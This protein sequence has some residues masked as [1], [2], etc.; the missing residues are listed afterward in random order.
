MDYAPALGL[1]EEVLFQPGK[2]CWKPP[3]FASGSLLVDGTAYYS[4]LY[5]TLLLAQERVFIQGWDFCSEV[6]LPTPQS[7]DGK[8]SIPLSELL[9]KLVDDRPHLEVKIL[10]WDAKPYFSRFRESQDDAKTVLAHPRI[11]L[12][13][14]SHLPTFA[15]FHQKLVV[16]DSSIAYVGGIDLT[17]NRMDDRR[18]SPKNDEASE[19]KYGKFLPIHDVQLR[20]TGS[21][22]SDIAE[23]ARENWWRATG[24]QLESAVPRMEL[25]SSAEFKWAPAVISRTR[26]RWQEWEEVREIEALLPNLIRSA[27]KYIYIECQYLSSDTVTAALRESLQRPQ[28]PEIVIVT[29]KTHHGWWEKR[30]LGI[31]R[32]RQIQKLRADDQHGRFDI[33]HPSLPGCED[34]FCVHSK[35]ILVDGRY[36]CVGSANLTNRSLGLDTECCVTFDFGGAVEGDELPSK[37]CQQLLAEHLDC[38]VDEIQSALAAHGSILKVIEAK[39]ATSGTQRTLCRLGSEDEDRIGRLLLGKKW[40]DPSEALRGQKFFYKWMNT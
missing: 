8:T 22:A 29:G 9:L 10:I 21:A 38:A 34:D 15:S 27:K 33:F 17:A 36:A 6:E 7:A 2:N 25:A 1:D 13:F 23:M 14:D 39:R 32:N 31:M 30:T 35:L 37:W 16:I 40:A 20:L 12:V 28:G 18:H 5:K 3:A 24:L 11:Q 26:A 4:D 19:K